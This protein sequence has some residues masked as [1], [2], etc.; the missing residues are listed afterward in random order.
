VPREPVRFFGSR[1]HPIKLGMCN[2]RHL[3]MYDIDRRQRERE[4]SQVFLAEKASAVVPPAV[5]FDRYFR[6]RRLCGY[7]G[8]KNLGTLRPELATFLADVQ[9]A[10]NDSLKN[11]NRQM[12]GHVEHPPFFFDYIDSD[13]PNALAFRDAGYSFIGLTMPLV[14][15]LW[16]SCVELSRSDAVGALL[17]IAP[18]LEREEAI[19]TVMFQNQLI[20]L[21][22]HEYTHHVHGHLSDQVPGSVFFEEIFINDDEGDLAL[23]AFEMDADGYAVYLALSHLMNGPR[24]EQATTVMSCEHAHPDSQDRVLFLSF[25][26]AIGAMLL[27]ASPPSVDFRKCRTPTHP[28]PAARMDWIMHHATNWCVEN[29]KSHLVTMTKGTFQALM[30]IVERAIL[31]IRPTNDWREQAAFLKSEIGS[32]YRRELIARLRKHVQAIL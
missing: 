4:L 24:R 11:E 21:V 12:P 1:F 7:R 8:K 6:K 19:L 10:L 15:S 2:T 16:D 32:Q 27:V 22:T 29:G 23:Q 3:G 28:F 13:E 9:S 26:M 17:E 31:Q 30:V 5:L 20:F 18:I 25:V 14:Y